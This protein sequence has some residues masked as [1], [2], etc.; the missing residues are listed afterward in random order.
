MKKIKYL[1]LS[2]AAAAIYSSCSSD[3]FLDERPDLSIPLDQAIT[4]ENSLKVGVNGL[5]NFL[6]STNTYGGAIP[7]LS[8]LLADHAFVSIKNSNRFALTRQSTLTFYSQNNGDISGVWST[9]YATIMNANNVL[10][11][12]GK[13]TDDASV[14][15]TPEELFAQAYAVRAMCYLDLVSFFAQ[16]PGGGNPELGIPI[17]TEVAFGSAKKRSTVAEVYAQILSDLNAANTDI[18][19]STQRKK[20]T[21]AGVNMLYSRYYLAMKD[22]PNANIYA[23][24][25]LDDNNSTLLAMTPTTNI[26]NFW[27]AAG[28]T[29]NELIFS[30]DYNANDL[31][32]ANDA[33]IATWYSGGTYKQNFATQDFYNMFS[34]TD[35]RKG[36]WYT[37]TGTG[38]NLAT[39]PDTPSPI[40]V[41]KYKTIDRDVVV[42]R[43]TEAVF[44]QLEALYRTDPTAA[45]AKLRSWVISY[46]DPGYNFNAT[47][48]PLLVEIL[49]QKNKEF[50][51][52]GFRYRDLKRNGLS[53]TNPQTGV[54]LSPSV[55]QFNAFPIPQSEMNTNPLMVQNPGY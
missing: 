6:Q 51:L 48:Q 4:N 21:K 27:T 54:S 33:I 11:N 23:Q 1:V 46:R 28:E 36:R 37:A 14:D 20:L 2:L 18:S 7:T 25:V 10:A 13:V 12:K 44:N 31:P 15:G 55:Y 43:K 45:L 3:R 30:I 19:A 38:V 32:G 52:E 9:L 26:A 17:H 29:N 39:Y 16:Y 47:G 50:F 41:T 42:I 8:E 40:D 24:K 35:V 5:Y 34:N 22:Y 49:N 53:F